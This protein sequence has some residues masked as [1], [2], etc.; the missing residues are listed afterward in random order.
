MYIIL[1][2]VVIYPIIGSGMC[3]SSL[4]Y[5]AG[6]IYSYLTALLLLV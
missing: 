6:N 1:A 5:M 4:F 3:T 2:V